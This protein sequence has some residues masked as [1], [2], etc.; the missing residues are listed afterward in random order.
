MSDTR[1]RYLIAI[2]NGSQSS[3]VTV[4]DQ[5]GT[6]VSEGVQE[7]RPCHTPRPGVVEHPDDDLWTSIG[8]AARRAMAGFTGDPADIAGVGLCT[9]RFCRAVLKGDGSLAQPVMSWMDERV[10]RPYEHTDPAAAKVTAS[11]GYITHRMTG[12]FRDTAANYAGLWPLDPDTWRWSEDESVLKSFGAPR[13]MLME[14]VLP[15]EVLGE[16]TR[17]AA[18]HTGIPAGLPVV[19]TA[20]DKAVEALGCG[21][22]SPDTLLV[23]LGTYVAGMT[24]GDCYIP[25]GDGFWSN[26]ASVPHAYLYESDGVRRGMWTVSWYR[27]LLGEEAVAQARAEGVSAEE[28]LNA[29]AAAVPPGSD[30]LITVLDWLA[31]TDAPF[32]KGSII[33]FDGRQGKHHIHRS[34]LEALALTVHEAAERMG[35]ALGTEFR[36][37]VVSGGGSNSDLVLQIF[38]DVFGVPAQRSAVAG[39]AGL[40]AAVCAA[41][42]TGVYPD[43]DR[44]VEAMVRGGEVFA[45]DAENHDLYRRLGAIHREVRA[46]TDPVFRRTHEIFG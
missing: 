44:A 36:E 15:G 9:I 33:G 18:E 21:L 42:G 45:P 22:R 13:E 2:D 16:V 32:R 24:T 30:G 46:H 12:H 37:V 1:P 40:G 8:E 35:A 4:F 28:Y 27:D 26:Y 25:D 11:S 5:H 20:N 7:L 3:K 34:I 43:H 6:A 23:S 19:A 41:V 38:A 29:G 31:P 14:L 10:S 39:A 17:E